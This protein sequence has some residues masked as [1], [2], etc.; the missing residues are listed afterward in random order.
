MP[1]SARSPALALRVSASVLPKRSACASLTS[2][3]RRQ[4]NRATD[5]KSIFLLTLLLFSAVAS[6]EEVRIKWKG[7]YPHN[8]SK[9][10]STDNPYHSGFSKNFKNGTPEEFG[11]VQKDGELNAFIYSPKGAKSPAPFVI[12]LHGCDGL[13]TLENEWTQH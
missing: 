10:W 12:V 11:D 13:S 7:D 6:A 2:R 9:H 4:T 1:G 5:M 3:R 8:S